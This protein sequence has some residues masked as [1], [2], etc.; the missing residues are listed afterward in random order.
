MTWPFLC[1][2]SE[3][4]ELLTLTPLTVNDLHCFS[5]EGTYVSQRFPSNTTLLA[6]VKLH[7]QHAHKIKV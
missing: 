5:S 7:F 6:S 3:K 4:I 2:F 1:G